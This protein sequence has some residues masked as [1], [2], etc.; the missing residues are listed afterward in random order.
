MKVF[1]AYG[2]PTGKQLAE[3]L[4]QWL[5]K[6]LPGI[7]LHFAP[8]DIAK[9][10]RW[11]DV[12][13]TELQRSAVTLLCLTRESLRRPWILYEAGS[14]SQHGDVFPLLFGV[15]AD[16]LSDGPL[17]QYQATEFGHDEMWRLVQALR[18]RP[19]M[20]RVSV[21]RLKHAFERAWPRLQQKVKGILSQQA[22]DM[23]D[24]A[25]GAW[26]EKITSD[27]PT[28]ISFLQIEPEKGGKTLR[29]LGTAYGPDGRPTAAWTSE[30]VLVDPD[31]AMLAYLWQGE[32]LTESTGK[33]RGIG[34]IF[35]LK[36]PGGKLEAGQ[37]SFD[38]TDMQSYHATKKFRLIRARR[39]EESLMTGTADRLKTALVK[40]KLAELK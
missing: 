16:L 19:S 9:G 6:V 29:L 36:S 2:G 33:R 8:W 34:E 23:V 21:P 24:Q 1:L 39:R 4:R 25:L 10:S 7:K 14:V 15:A 18:E 17:E 12:L 32:R 38:D 31:R 20:P 3:Q 28:S 37:G 30:I 13:G 5:P 22:Q 27:E 11:R 26:W 40:R 35:F